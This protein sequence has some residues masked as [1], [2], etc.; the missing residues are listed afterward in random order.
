[1]LRG[2]NAQVCGRPQ[3]KDRIVG[4]VDASNGAWPW[5]IDIQKDNAHICGGSL[6]TQD[7]VL[8]A[9]H[10]FPNDSIWLPRPQ[11]RQRHRSPAAVQLRV[12]EQLRPACVFACVGN[13]VSLWDELLRHGLGKH[14]GRR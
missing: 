2:S 5:Q 8:S 4:G 11:Q 7:W 9:A 14:Q 13:V 6:I 1:G 10:C 3:L 12:L